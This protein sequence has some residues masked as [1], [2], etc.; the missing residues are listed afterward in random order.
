[1][2]EALDSGSDTIVA[3]VNFNLSSNVEVLQFDLFGASGPVGVLTGTGNST[4]NWM[5]GTDA[6]DDRLSGL[7]GNDFLE[8]YGDDDVLL[9]GTGHD[10]LVGADGDDTPI[11]GL[12][13]DNYIGG[14]GDDLYV[15]DADDLG[16]IEDGG[17]GYDTVSLLFDAPPFPDY[18]NGTFEMP[19]NIE[20][21]CLRGT[22]A[23]DVFGNA[24]DNL[25][26]G[27]VGSDELLGAAGADTLRGG[28]GDDFLVGQEGRDKMTGGEG[29]DTFAI[30]SEYAGPET[31]DRSLDFTSGTDTL[32]FGYLGSA[33]PLRAAFFLAADDVTGVATSAT[34]MLCYD[35]DSGRLWLDYGR[36]SGLEYR[37]LIAV[38]HG[39]PT[40]QAS[41]ITVVSGISDYWLV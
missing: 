27:G 6:T 11:G 10:Y 3:S 31:L 8:G 25:I 35:T 14:N 18:P 9:G 32:R 24:S 23:V 29:A 4:A 33:Q 21:P 7:G 12:G 34:P 1:V 30:D 22:W 40:L 38:L 15:L 41:D 17:G 37:L 5:I 28:A 26:L 19:D 2:R 16:I 13:S 20:V 39:A 36:D